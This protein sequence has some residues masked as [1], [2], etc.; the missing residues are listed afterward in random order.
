VSPSEHAAYLAPA[1]C[2][3]CPLLSFLHLPSPSVRFLG[4]AR[5]TR[6]NPAMPHI[7]AGMNQGTR[8]KTPSLLFFQ[9]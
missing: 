3:F 2:M 9:P 8:E 7:W 6:E 4:Q 5:A 1:L